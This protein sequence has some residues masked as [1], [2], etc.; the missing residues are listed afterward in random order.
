MQGELSD[1]SPPD[2]SFGFGNPGFGFNYVAADNGSATSGLNDRFGFT[3]FAAN[4]L[5]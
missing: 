1:P 2:A 3:K 5:P 4:D